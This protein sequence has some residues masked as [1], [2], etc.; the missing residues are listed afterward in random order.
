[1]STIDFIFSFLLTWS[2]GLGLPAIVRYGIYRRPLERNDAIFWSLGLGFIE[3]LFFIWSGSQSKTHGVLV[4][5]GFASFRLLQAKPRSTNVAQVP[6]AET[7]SNKTKIADVISS[8]KLRI[9]EFSAKSAGPLH[10]GWIRILIVIAICWLTAVGARLFYELDGQSSD[11][12][13]T[14]KTTYPPEFT[15]QQFE[16]FENQLRQKLKG[17][18]HSPPAISETPEPQ[19]FYDELVDQDRESM[20]KLLASFYLP[21]LSPDVVSSLSLELSISTEKIRDLESTARQYLQVRDLRQTMQSSPVLYAKVMGTKP[22]T[23]SVNLAALLLTLLGPFLGLLVLW[24]VYRWIQQ[25][26]QAEG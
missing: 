19:S 7:T 24:V 20:I 2:V 13:L 3:L 15:D 16:H 17:V 1:M 26:F 11:V 8:F 4:L 21:R 10:L 6:I 22:D 25:G 23:Y 9:S 12:A 14:Y 18:Q 5:I